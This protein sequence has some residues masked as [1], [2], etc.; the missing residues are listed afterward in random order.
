MRMLCLRSCLSFFFITLGLFWTGPASAELATGKHF[1]WRVRNVPQP[2]Y[3]LG[4][5]HALRRSDY[6][7]GR[8]IDEAIGQCRRFVFEYDSYHTDPRLWQR[9]ML[10][11]QHYR[12]GTTLKDKIRPET[13]AQIQRIAKVRASEYDDVKPWA[14]AYFMM[15]HPYFHDIHKRYGTD[16]YVIRRA[17]PFAE[18][19][20]LETLD[21]HI[22]V[23]A[24]MSDV[25]SEVF[26]L[27]TFVHSDRI[28]Q[29]MSNTI[30]AYKRGDTRALA[31]ANAFE[32][33]ES[34]FLTSR[35]IDQRNAAWIPRIEQEIRSGKATMIVVGARHLCGPH[36]VIGLLQGRGYI[37]EQ[38]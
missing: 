38:L 33:R 7:L 2:I 36:N 5:I 28:A 11:A 16:A 26:L 19:A 25:E 21:E 12:A 1:L 14:I 29:E 8:E 24:S 13:Y 4:S 15:S 32:D 20:G 10:E 18:Y 17:S 37:L 31:A 27:Q 3:L 30:A 34:P 9:K 35:I 23:L 6:P 22:R